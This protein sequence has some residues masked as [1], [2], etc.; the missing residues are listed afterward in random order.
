MNVQFVVLTP[1]LARAARAAIGL[2]LKDAA[3]QAGIGINTL[4]RFEMEGRRDVSLDTAYKIAQ[5]YQERGIEFP[6]DRTMRMK[7]EMAA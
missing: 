5:F 7:A 4:N 6:D 1:V 3:K 2:A